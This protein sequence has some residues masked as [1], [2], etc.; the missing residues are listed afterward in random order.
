MRHEKD[1]KGKISN[2][3]AQDSSSIIGKD[4]DIDS[5]EC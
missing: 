5:A 2:T 4:S 1:L 3:A